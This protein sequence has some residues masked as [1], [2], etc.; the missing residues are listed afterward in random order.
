[1]RLSR[2]K[3]LPSASAPTLALA[4]MLTLALG[5]VATPALGE[6]IEVRYREAAAAY[7]RLVAS[8]GAAPGQ[9]REVAEDFYSLFGEHTGH[10][11]GPDGLSYNKC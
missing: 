3:L 4:L 2:V 5:L 1:M 7:H 8:K 9:W 6:P 11:R 10:S